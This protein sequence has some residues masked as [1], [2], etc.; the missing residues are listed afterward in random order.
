[1]TEKSG[2]E[3]D[4][5]IGPG[6]RVMSDN[7]QSGRADGDGGEG[8]R[9]RGTATRR[10]RPSRPCRNSS[11]PRTDRY[12]LPSRRTP[13]DAAPTRHPTARETATSPACR[14]RR[15]MTARRGYQQGNGR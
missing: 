13:L 4:D 1:M 9:Q 3:L 7:L 10:Q 5:N 2:C 11:R 6:G 15:P 14:R 12:H 8:R